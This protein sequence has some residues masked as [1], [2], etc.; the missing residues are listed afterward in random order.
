MCE[1]SCCKW[2]TY[3]KKK[4]EKT[5][6]KSLPDKQKKSHLEGQSHITLYIWT[7]RLRISL[8]FKRAVNVV[9]RVR[10]SNQQI[11]RNRMRFVT[12]FVTPILCIFKTHKDAQWFKS[13]NYFNKSRSQCCSVLQAVVDV[14]PG[15][16]VRLIS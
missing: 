1:C 11:K 12:M 15:I 9:W 16:L 8:R 2:E 5:L 14:F 3:K 6:L 7:R 4:T 13:N 10:K